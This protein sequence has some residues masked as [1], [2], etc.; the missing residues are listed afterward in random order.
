MMNITEF[1]QQHPEFAFDFAKLM[2]SQTRVYD[3]V[4]LE[5]LPEELREIGPYTKGGFGRANKNQTLTHKQ[6]GTCHRVLRNDKF[7]STPAAAKV[8]ILTTHCIECATKQNDER[9]NS[10]SEGYRRSREAIWRY[11]APKC[12]I[13]GFDRHPAAMDMHH[14]GEKEHL[15]SQ[16]IAKLAAAPL[17][18]NAERLLAEA[19]KCLPLCSNCHRLLHAG[20]VD[21]PAEPDKPA[22]DLTEVMRIAS[23]SQDSPRPWQM[24]LLREALSE[25]Y[26]IDE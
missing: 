26:R 4:I 17:E 11:V 25:P 21:L 19:V 20:I 22:Y 12:V 6:C 24:R 13:C 14:T 1:C 10:R 15:L 18:H 3:L 16:L 5:G 8:N 9:Y 2:K 23:T 7:W